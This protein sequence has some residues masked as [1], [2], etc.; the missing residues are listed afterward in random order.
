M[1]SCL[2]ID[3]LVTAYVDGELDAV[4]QAAIDQH[5]GVCAPCHSRVAAERAMRQLLRQR[6]D[7]LRAGCAPSCLRAA[8]AGYADAAATR[9]EA[10]SVPPSWR[11]RLVPLAT[12][13]SLVLV[14]GGVFVYQ[15]TE[16]SSYV[17]AAELAAD[18]LKCFTMNA[19]LGTQHTPE[20]VESAMASGFGWAMRL[21]SD[22]GRAGLELV[23]S[24]PCLYGEGKIA[25]IM[26]RHNGQ[27]VSLFMLPGTV[28]TDE[29]VR[30]LG[31][32]CVI[33][34][35]ED[36]TFVLVAR[37]GREEVERLAAVVHAGLGQSG[38]RSH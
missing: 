4:D 38:L 2:Q 19:V 13:A 20:I 27:P 12:A 22:A 17:M 23:G 18:H 16:R 21:P 34:S 24:R 10:H 6:Q 9:R 7:G 25:H 11:A 36:R 28:R 1:R 14:V 30:T 26:Y 5:I 15:L 31:H 33:W 35:A 37:E 8:C 29:I 32:E 3:S